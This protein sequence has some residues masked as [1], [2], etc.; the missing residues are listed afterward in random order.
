MTPVRVA[1]VAVNQTPL[2]WE[3]NERNILQGLL[4]AR[5]EQ[6]HIVCFP[7]MCISGY[8]CEDAFLWPATRYSSLE[9][10][11][12][13]LPATKG[14]FVSV[15]LPLKVDGKIFNAMAAIA[16][17]ELLGF[18]CKRH[19]AGDGLHYEPR[20]FSAWPKG[21]QKTITVFGRDV[22]VGDLLFELSGVRLGFEICEDAWVPERPAGELGRAGAALILGPSAS[23]FAFDKHLKRREL[24]LQGVRDSGAAY[25]YCN[26][27]GNE[28]GRVVYDGDCLIASAEGEPHFVAEARRLSFRDFTLACATLELD[29]GRTSA[30]IM[31][32]V[33]FATDAPRQ[34]VHVAWKLPPAL[35]R[36]AFTEP[37]PRE[38]ARGRLPKEDAFARAVALGLFDYL[39]KSRSRGFIV[40]LSGGADS[41]AVAILVRLMLRFVIQERGLAESLR[42]LAGLLPEVQEEWTE[43]SL[44]RRL[45]VTVYQGTKNSSDVTRAAAQSVAELVGA[46]HHEL[47][48]DSLVE[49]YCE[50]TESMLGRKLSWESDDVA[51][52]NIQA[53][54][55]APSVWMLANV[56]GAL[57]LSTSNRSEAAVG[58]ATMDGDTC[59]GLA[60]IAGVDKA[61]LRRWL[62]YLEKTGLPE[63]GAM[64]ALR[65][66][67]EQQPTAELRPP[68][69]TQ[70]DE[71]DLMPYEV[72]DLIERAAVVRRFPP[73]VVQKMV[74]QQFAVSQEQAHFWITRFYSLFTRNQWKRERYAP[75]FHLDEGNLDPRSWC[76][77]PILSGGFQKE[78]AALKETRD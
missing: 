6:A 77:F 57:L 52:Q 62:V 70:T 37:T 51:L 42:C 11:K 18:V 60:P 23:H 53:R 58:Y 29:E 76:R 46:E 1:A 71:E 45:L 26:L 4:A 10:L 15:G 8:G 25:L 30:G 9:V 21:V 7:E 72:L 49:Q 32:A 61:F 19:L 34:T 64:P 63:W 47:N 56:R 68:S 20:W 22:P 17:G 24:V 48:V 78:L 27:L 36:E 2:A 73:E 41:A 35:K 40:S 67:N 33:A 65:A 14:L 3:A 50:L 44:A 74:A 39:R 38:D 43:E 13:L 66:V 5:G 69:A 55:R 28:A 16:D 12:A 75:S 54:V 59:G 31:Q